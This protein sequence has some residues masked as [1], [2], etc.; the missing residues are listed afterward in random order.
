MVTLEIVLVG[1]AAGDQCGVE[2]RVPIEP[3]VGGVGEQALLKGVACV[4]DQR[5]G[6]AP[7]DLSQCIK[8]KRHE[9]LVPVDPLVRTGGGELSFEPISRPGKRIIRAPGD[10]CALQHGADEDRRERDASDSLG[11]RG[12]IHGSGGLLRW[13]RLFQSSPQGGS[14]MTDRNKH[15]LL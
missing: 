9:R 6:T 15:T 10:R 4:F 1:H 13:N 2:Q 7:G 5:V 12:G 3:A 14:A 11:K 8:R